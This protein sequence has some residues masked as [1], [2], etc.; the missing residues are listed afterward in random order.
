[1]VRNNR[2]TRNY[3][4]A[5]SDGGG[6]YCADGSSPVIVNNV[7]V[8][9]DATTRGGGIAVMPGAVPT[10]VNNTIED[11]LAVYG[12]GIYCGSAGAVVENN[13]VAHSRGGGGLWAEP[14]VQPASDYNDVW[15]N[16][17]GNY[18]PAALQGSHDVSLDPQFFNAAVDDYRLK[19]VSPCIDRGDNSA[20]RLPDFDFDSK[21]RILDGNGDALDVVDMGA[22]EFDN[23]CEG[24]FNGDGDVDGLDLLDFSFYYDQQQ[25][26][27]ADLNGDFLI[28]AA[29]LEAFAYDYGRHNCPGCGELPRSLP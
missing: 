20:A 26:P 5:G 16:I 6:I 3:A 2:I 7:I 28:D 10:I 19:S 18:V 13:I 25:F 27:E 21:P 11:N 17:G 22:Y 24:D 9:N 8:H 4:T 1:M 15:D 29:D 12:G 14:G 23:R